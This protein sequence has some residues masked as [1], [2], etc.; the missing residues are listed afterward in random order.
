M[1]LVFIFALP[2]NNFPFYT[3]GTLKPLALVPILGFIVIWFI[4][5]IANSK[6]KLNSL[7]KIL[8]FMFYFFFFT[9]LIM[10]WVNF[11]YMSNVKSISPIIRYIQFVFYSIISV[12]AYFIGKKSLDIYDIDRLLKTILIAFFPSFLIGTLQVVT[13]NAPFLNTIRSLFATTVFPTGYY[14]VMMLSTEPSHAAIDLITY[15]IPITVY[16]IQKNSKKKLSYILLLLQIFL[17][18]LTKSTL[19]YILM[20]C[21]AI[22]HLFNTLKNRGIK[23]ASR[24]A[25]LVVLIII[26]FYISDVYLMN[27]RNTDFFLMRI[28]KSIA[29]TDES[30]NTRVASYEV[31][32]KAFFDY[33]IIGIG[34]RNAGYFYAKYVNPNF[35]K[36][37]LI[38]D[39]TSV[40]SSRFADV[41]ATVLEILVS[42]GIIG[43]SVF[44]VFCVV[45][46]KYMKKI[47]YQSFNLYLLFTELIILTLLGSFS[48]SIFGF[49]IFWFITGGISKYYTYYAVDHNSI[50]Q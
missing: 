22:L 15:T 34:F 4:K 26:T 48:Y 35:L 31:A 1:L 50:K 23:K 46:F 38:R 37:F 32:L 27:S 40:S 11:D 20:V 36:Y 30:S 41:K 19:G 8:I 29:L 5:G 18:I 49:P 17:L 10:M 42:S 13:N 21:F 9:S 47:K 12:G 6:F 3:G 45:L 28:Q 25:F 39:Y 43:F 14:R 2:Y 33:P 44:L 24:Y 16:F 7:D